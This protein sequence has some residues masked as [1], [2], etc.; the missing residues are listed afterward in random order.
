LKW[1]ANQFGQTTLFGPTEQKAKIAELL[2]ELSNFDLAW[3]ITQEYQLE[4]SQIYKNAFGVLAR[5]KQTTSIK[6][7]MK[8]I[9]GMM[10]DN[11]WDD[12][13]ISVIDVYANE[14]NDKKTA[15]GFLGHLKL[16]VSKTH[17]FIA[18]KK[19][20]S[21]Y[22]EAVKEEVP[23]SESIFLVEKIYDEAKKSDTTK[24]AELCEKYLST[25]NNSKDV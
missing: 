3:K 5:K 23:L 1:D 9:K 25:H 6:E 22:I 21:A 8:G 7:I 17:G 12:L 10:D 18:C 19:L 14:L 20:R 4:I 15:E 11:E 24:V 13:V 16:L 2:L